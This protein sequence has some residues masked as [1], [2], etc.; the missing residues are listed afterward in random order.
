M[1]IDLWEAFRRLSLWVE[2][3]CI[4]EW[5]LFSERVEQVDGSRIDRGTIY[6]LLT[7]R[8][9]NR[10]P[11]TWERNQVDLLI[12]EGRG[13]TCPWTGRRIAVPGEY[14][15]D[16]LI[17]VSIYPINE[18]WNLVPSDAYFNSHQKRDRL[19]APERL[20]SAQLHLASTYANYEASPTLAIAIHQDVAVQFSRVEYPDFA[21]G[22]AA[23]VVDFI[24]VAEARNIARFG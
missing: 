23:T 8:P 17:P 11:L 22:V 9:D 6:T 19:P 7:A 14:D 5:C 18:L 24:A 12:M 10:R 21:S 15:M 16:H 1:S 20:A 4:H 13:F 2:A 3:L